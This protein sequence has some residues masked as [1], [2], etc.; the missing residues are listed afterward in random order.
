LI[1]HRFRTGSKSFGSPLDLELAGPRIEL[2]EI[3][4]PIEHSQEAFQ[5][6]Q[7]RHHG[8]GRGVAAFGRD[9]NRSRGTPTLGGTRKHGRLPHDD[10]FRAVSQLR[11]LA[12]FPV[13]TKLQVRIG[14][15]KNVKN[16]SWI[17]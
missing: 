6:N 17:V 5:N 9:E 1:L 16:R 14:R 11:S 13:A 8:A 4:N 2:W 10:S 12:G 3:G 15:Q 7:A